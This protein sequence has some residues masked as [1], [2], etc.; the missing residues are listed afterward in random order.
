MPC[1]SGRDNQLRVKS[2]KWMVY[3]ETKLWG[4]PICGNH[5]MYSFVIICQQDICRCGERHCRSSWYARSF[6][7]LYDEHPHRPASLGCPD[8]SFHGIH[9]AKTASGTRRKVYSKN[10]APSMG[11]RLG[12]ASACL[13]SKSLLFTLV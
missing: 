3:D 7:Q 2:P 1:D 5:R 12:F 9:V 10:N 4:T 11:V 13:L 8:A 6:H